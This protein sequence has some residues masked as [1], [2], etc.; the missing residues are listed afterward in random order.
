MGG[1]T[2]HCCAVVATPARASRAARIPSKQ[3]AAVAVRAIDRSPDS[4][5]A[6]THCPDQLLSQLT[7]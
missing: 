5:V 7:A 3:L 1:F 6:L 4:L 2:H